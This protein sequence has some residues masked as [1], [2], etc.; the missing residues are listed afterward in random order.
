MTTQKL[1]REQAVAIAGLRGVDA[2]GSMMCEPTCR[3]GFNGACQGDELTEY[4]A[5]IY[6]YDLDA[7]LS[8]YYYAT[9]EDDEAIANDQYTWVISHYTVEFD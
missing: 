4:R 6:L 9:P 8:A 3:L 2:V 1:T 7:T 5:W